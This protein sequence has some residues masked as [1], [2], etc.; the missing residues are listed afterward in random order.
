MAQV[1]RV[2][3]SRTAPGSSS[4]RGDGRGTEAR[5]IVN[6]KKL[7]GC[8]N[9]GGN[10][11]PLRFTL[12][13]RMTSHRFPATLCVF[14]VMESDGKGATCGRVLVCTM[15]ALRYEIFHTEQQVSVTPRHVR[16]SKKGTTTVRSTTSESARLI[17]YMLPS[18]VRS[19]IFRA[20][21]AGLAYVARAGPCTRSMR[22]WHVQGLHQ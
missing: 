1:L 7:E 13:L 19:A 9:R 11:R 4:V 22:P 3:S 5:A 17:A 6:H 16:N 12:A 18:D 8:G 10:A 21:M 14:C 2:G 20:H 15:C